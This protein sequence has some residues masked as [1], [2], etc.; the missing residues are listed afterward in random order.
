[1][2]VFPAKLIVVNNVFELTGGVLAFMPC[3]PYALADQVRLRAKDH[4]EL[5]RPNGTLLQTTLYGLVRSSPSDGAVGISISPF[6]KA[7]VPI[8]TE[9]WKV[10]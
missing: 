1:M 6:T 5:R 8:G 7:D 4:L 2:S 10:G 3:V 9:I